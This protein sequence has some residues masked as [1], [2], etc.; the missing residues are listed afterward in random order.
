M[1]DFTSLKAAKFTESVI[2]EMTRVAIKN[3][4]VN[5]AQG[6][7]DFPAPD[8]IKIA[9]AKAIFNDCNQYAITWGTKELRDALVDKV[10]RDYNT[11]LDAEKHITVCCGATEGM[12]ATL[13]ATVNP[14]DEVIIFEPFYENY[15]ADVILCGAVPRYIT[16]DAPDYTFD[17]EKLARLFNEKTRAIILN[18]P[19]NPT[20]KVFTLDELEFIAN[21]CQTYDALA[22][23]D[24]IYEH[25]LFDGTKHIPIWTLPHMFERT[26]AVNSVSKTYSVTGWRIGFVTASAALTSAIRKVHD[27]LTVGAA[28]PLQMAVADALHFGKEYYD[29]LS[30][31]YLERRDFMLKVLNEVGF[32]CVVP[33]G[34][35]YIMADITNFGY[36]DDVEFAFYLAE[37]IGVAV[38]PGS[39]FYRAGEPDGKRYV[40]F[41]FCKE[42][43]TL[44]TAANR[45]AKLK[46]YA[47]A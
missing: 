45:L 29:D 24:E 28:A 46:G 43:S 5:L 18:T 44:Q 11:T 20:G 38:V 1:K 17:K 8:A 36:D 21:L 31:F 16:L 30:S 12:I 32:K 4:A 6:F 19:N 47:K 26:I 13:L 22:I 41:C 3:N 25:I 42:F 23:N 35:Y 14:G 10:K 34:A 27:F 37:K 39:T 15:G 9:A 7:P 2:R 33:H 40:R